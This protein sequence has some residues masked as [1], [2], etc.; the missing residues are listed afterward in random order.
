MT[1][2]MRALGWALWM[3]REYRGW[4]GFFGA[5]M[6]ADSTAYFARYEA[7]RTGWGRP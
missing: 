1:P 4:V 6:N 7:N 5:Q 2:N 3:T